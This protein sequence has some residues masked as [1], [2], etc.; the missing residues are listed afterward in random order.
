MHL[1]YCEI[2]MGH[3]YTVAHDWATAAGRYLQAVTFAEDLGQGDYTMTIIAIGLAKDD[4]RA[5]ANLTVAMP[6]DPVVLDD[7]DRRLAQ[8]QDRIAISSATLQARPS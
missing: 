7:L 1:G 5:L 4:L 2:L 6:I 3:K 8:H